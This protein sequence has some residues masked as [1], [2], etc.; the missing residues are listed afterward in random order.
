VAKGA[1]FDT[2]FYSPAGSTLVFQQ[3]DLRGLAPSVVF[4][5]LF[6]VIFIVKGVEDGRP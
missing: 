5:D 1:I 3:D 6:Q 2:I 4:P